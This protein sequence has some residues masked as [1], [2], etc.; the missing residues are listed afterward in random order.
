MLLSAPKR[1][2]L[3]SS[4]VRSGFQAQLIARRRPRLAAVHTTSQVDLL[5]AEE[6]RVVGSQLLAFPMPT[7]QR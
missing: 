2:M 5:G 6:G 4:Q 7:D 3:A 1:T